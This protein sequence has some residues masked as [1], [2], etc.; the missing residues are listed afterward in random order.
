MNE[1]IFHVSETGGI[2]RF[3]PRPTAV[4][5][6]VAGAVVWG[7]GER[8]LHNYLLPRNCPRVTFYAVAETTAADKERFLGQ[9][10][11]DYVIAVESGWLER[12]RGTTL[13]VYELPTAAFEVVDEGADYYVARRAVRPTAVTQ[14]DDP[15]AALLARGVELRLT[16]SLGPLAEAVV[17]SSLQFSLIRM[18][19]AK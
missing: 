11:A 10:A 6:A 1:R 9:T 13:Y 15:L 16:P 5:S 12:V 18:R 19:Y 7:I 14:V 4:G 8:L 2:E 17:T 3:E